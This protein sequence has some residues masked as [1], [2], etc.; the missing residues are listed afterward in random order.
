[1]QLNVANAVRGLCTQR[2]TIRV[3]SK[4]LRGA[5]PASTRLGR[6]RRGPSKLRNRQRTDQTRYGVRR[7]GAN[8]HSFGKCVA[9][10]SGG[11]G[12]SVL[13]PRLRVDER[14]EQRLLR[15]GSRWLST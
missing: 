15:F 8:Q 3:T 6:A 9:A 11:R 1:S 5:H 12:W 13:Q 14:S 2:D 7:L 4:L 10:Q